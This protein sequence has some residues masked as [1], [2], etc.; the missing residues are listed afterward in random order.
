[1]MTMAQ[2]Q[3][4]DLLQ[5]LQIH[6]LNSNIRFD[7]KYSFYWQYAIFFLFFRVDAPQIHLPENRINLKIALEILFVNLTG[8]THSKWNLTME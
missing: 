8:S 1:M 4:L 5:A 2:G 6:S 3:I 7:L